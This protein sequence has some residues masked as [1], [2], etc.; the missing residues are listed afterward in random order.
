MVQQLKIIPFLETVNRA[1]PKHIS[2]LVYL[3]YIAEESY[4]KVIKKK[5]GEE[6]LRLNGK[7]NS[8]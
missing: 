6:V 1:D 5:V 7:F 3:L 8:T 2:K 4:G